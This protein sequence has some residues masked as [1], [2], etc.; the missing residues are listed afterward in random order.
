MSLNHA[1]GCRNATPSILDLTLDDR[2][3]LDHNC[4]HENDAGHDCYYLSDHYQLALR[5][6]GRF[7]LKT[8]EKDVKRTGRQTSVMISV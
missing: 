7:R 2:R 5:W 6:P 1:E 3:A 8:S 4:V